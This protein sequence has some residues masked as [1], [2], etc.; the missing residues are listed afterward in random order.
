MNEI[1][2]LKPRE[3][4]S[5][6]QIIRASLIDRTVGHMIVSRVDSRVIFRLIKLARI[7]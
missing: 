7:I 3:E 6:N 5:A 4:L 1:K 2:I